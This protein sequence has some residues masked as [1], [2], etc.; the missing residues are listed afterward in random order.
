MGGCFGGVEV[1]HSEN[2][3]RPAVL[4]TQSAM[5][6]VNLIFQD[7][8]GEPDRSTVGDLGDGADPAQPDDAVRDGSHPV[9]HHQLV[10]AS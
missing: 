8:H 9:H 2:E 5:E 3:T 1:G 10:G 4:R 7:L 6:V